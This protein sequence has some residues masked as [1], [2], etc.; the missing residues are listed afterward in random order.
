VP[1]WKKSPPKH[2]SFK[3]NAER[4]LWRYGLSLAIYNLAGRVTEGGKNPFFAKVPKLRL[5][6]KSNEESTRRA[7]KRLVNAGWL[8]PLP[9]KGHYTYVDHDTRAFATNEDCVERKDLPHWSQDADPFAGKIFAVSGGT[10]RV[11]PHW[12]AAARKNC[13]EQEFLDALRREFETGSGSP[14]TRFW[15]VVRQFRA[16]KSV[17]A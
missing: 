11:Q 6:F 16:S 15:N 5:Y 7:F 3:C 4:H 1:T 17:P 2:N 8:E 9:E 10:I 14:G 13:S 12:L